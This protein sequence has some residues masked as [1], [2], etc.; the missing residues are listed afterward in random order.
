M[1]VEAVEKAEVNP[2]SYTDVLVSRY[3]Y[4]YERGG[5]TYITRW[6]RVAFKTT[7]EVRTAFPIIP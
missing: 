4:V 5:R 1:I 7:G 3:S 6:V 2:G